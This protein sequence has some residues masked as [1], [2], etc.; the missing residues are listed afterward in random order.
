MNKPILFVAPR[1]YPGVTAHMKHYEATGLGEYSDELSRETVEGKKIVILGAWHPIYYEAI[2][3]LRRENLQIWLYW[4]SS[5]GQIDFS[6]G[7]IETVSYTHL[8]LPT[9]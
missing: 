1:D 3:K 4:T 2:K 7:G 8:T 9:N 6:N 5:V